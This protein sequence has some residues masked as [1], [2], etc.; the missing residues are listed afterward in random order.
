MV[1]DNMG[2]T[3]RDTV[4]VIVTSIQS[5]N[6]VAFSNSIRVYP[7]PVVN[8]TTLEINK[9]VGNSKVLEVITDAQ[10]K[11]ILVKEL[12]SLQN[13]ILEKIDMSNLS[14]GIYLVT[15]FFNEDEK[16]TLKVLKN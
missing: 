15:I 11:T 12:S 7:N 5:P 1:T 13:I 3:S 4:K 8:T 9:A 16:Q 10:G 6:P 2:A 14:K